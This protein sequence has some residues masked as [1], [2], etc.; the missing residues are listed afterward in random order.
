[1]DD[2]KTVNIVV[3]GRT[4]PIKVTLSEE[5]TVRLL[6]TDLNRKIS[7]F[8]STYPM[9]DKLDCVIMTMLTYI[10]DLNKSLLPVDY[11]ALAE[12]IEN[13]QTIIDNFDER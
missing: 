10:D 13:I 12:K 11:E 2:L 8:Q 9:R 5:S 4:F 1:M 7:E 6:E 3:A